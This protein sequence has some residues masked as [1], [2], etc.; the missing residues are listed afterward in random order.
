M[1]ATL[2]DDRLST[3]A[4]IWDAAWDE[5]D[6]AVQTRRGP[7]RHPVLATIGVVGPEVRTVVLRLADKQRAAF[8]V[9]TD[10]R[11]AKVTEISAD[12]RVGLVAWDPDILLQFRVRGTASVTAGAPVAER[13]DTLPPAARAS[14]AAIVV[15]GERSVGDD[16]RTPTPDA[17]HFAVVE[18]TAS[19]IELLHLGEERHR[20][21]VF[22]RTDGWNGNWVQP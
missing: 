21:G 13:W 11:T 12:P 6:V 4:G 17:R 5:L 9:Y 16:Q 1:T 7:W 18:I 2:N 22:R 20:R 10:I 15:P 14:Y 8:E 19:E 3:L